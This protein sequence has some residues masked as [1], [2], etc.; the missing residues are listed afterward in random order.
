M[1]RSRRLTR[2]A[3]LAVC[4]L[5]PLL[6]ATPSRPA[7]A[8]PSAAQAPDAP[9]P[10]AQAPR[11]PAPAPPPPAPA[12]PAPTPTSPPP[13]QPLEVVVTGTRTPESSQRATVRTRVISREEA[14]RRGATNV[15]EA[16][17]GELGVQVNP[18][19]YGA[20]GNP[21]AIQIQGFD[22]DRVLV[23]EDGERVIGDAGGAIDLSSLPLGDVS[24][25]ELVTGPTSSLYGTSAIGGIVNVLT[26]PP[27]HPGFSGRGRLEVRSRAG[28]L[29]QASGAYRGDRAWASADASFQREDSLS[30]VEPA[31]TP[32]T[33][34]DPPDPPDP[35]D[36]PDPSDPPA[37]SSPPPTPSAASTSSAAAPPPC[38]R[39][40]STSSAC[41]P[42]PRSA[43]ASTCGSARAGSTTRRTA[44]SGWTAPASAPT[45]SIS[46]R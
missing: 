46:P 9:A 15:G 7:L 21:S 30:L 23:L 33:P 26:A 42:A 25:I 35:P 5:P 32:A 27:A 41:A 12:P 16:L 44:S 10:D 3:H 39:A 14:E 31:A 36:L 34:A 19:A 40:R 22:L 29:V 13:A 45:S 28:L 8:Q 4:L 43:T 2:A 1:P 38:P 11:P 24:R 6:S 37:P 17:D 20:L 18:S